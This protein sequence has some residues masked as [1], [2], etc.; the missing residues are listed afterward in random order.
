M[1]QMNRLRV[2][3]SA[4]GA[5]FL[6]A[7]AQSCGMAW[8]QSPATGIRSIDFKNFLYPYVHPSG[9]PDHL[10]WMSLELVA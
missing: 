8:S 5:V 2:S 9:W 3:L 10:Q 4:T 6:L 1:F 7:I